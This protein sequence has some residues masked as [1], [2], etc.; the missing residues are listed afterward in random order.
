[1]KYIA[2][3][4]TTDTDNSNSV[5]MPQV[6][7]CFGESLNVYLTEVGARKLADD[8]L[9]NANFLWPLEEE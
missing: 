4:V 1:M 3:G 5:Q 9:R 2:V 6:A 7:V 8:L